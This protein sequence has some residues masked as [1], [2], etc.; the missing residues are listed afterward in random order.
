LEISYKTMVRVRYNSDQVVKFVQIT[1]DPIA[2]SLS[3]LKLN[4][5]QG[6]ADRNT[7]RLLS[8]DA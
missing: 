2:I 4:I 3:N 8:G 5:A 1:P 7:G 6:M